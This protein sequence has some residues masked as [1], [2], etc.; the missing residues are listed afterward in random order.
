MTVCKP[1]KSIWSLLH[2]TPRIVIFCKTGSFFTWLGSLSSPRNALLVKEGSEPD[3]FWKALGGGS[4]YSKEMCINGWHVDPHLYSCSVD[5]GL[6]KFKEI[7]NFCQD[8]LVTQEIL[9]LDGNKE[10]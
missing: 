7:F 8:D 10:I 9:I 1:Y 3:H 2:L 6:L 4:E 5:Q